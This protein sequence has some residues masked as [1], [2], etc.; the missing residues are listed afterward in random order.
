[1]VKK[2]KP[3]QAV[4]PWEL[5]PIDKIKPYPNNARAHPPAQITLLADILRKHGPDQPIVVDEDGIILKGHGR[6]LAAAEANITQ[7]PV[8]QRCGMS[9]SEK[10]AMRIADNAIAL[11]STWD[12]DLMKTELEALQ[13]SGY[14]V[15]L[16]GFDGFQL[17]EFMTP[18]N[19]GEVDPEQ[20]P[21]T[22]KNPIVRKGD[23]WLLGNHRLL[24]G[25][26][27]SADDARKVMGGV[28]PHLM[29]ITYLTP[30]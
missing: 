4:G 27:T 25:D 3:L 26:S 23:L 1:M 21:E 30:S 14:D 8:I 7:F 24:C 6:L 16:L 22:P 11:L 5:W 18:P 19:A 28:V 13:L 10:S 9:Q 20:T 17:A 2:S 29:G 12:A 15:A